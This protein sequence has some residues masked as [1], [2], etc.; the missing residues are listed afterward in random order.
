MAPEVA[1]TSRNSQKR[2]RNGAVKNTLNSYTGEKADMFSLG[3]IL[4]TMYFGMIPFMG[5]YTDDQLF[6]DATSGDLEIAENF[7]NN[8]IFTKG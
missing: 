3:V 1:K 6:K 5:D 4:F 8:N 2:N 7:F